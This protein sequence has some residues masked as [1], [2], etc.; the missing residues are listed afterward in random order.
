MVEPLQSS[1]PHGVAR[2]KRG[3]EL[4]VKGGKRGM[5]GGRR[6]GRSEVGVAF[7]TNAHTSLCHVKQR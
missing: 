7:A 2:R 4:L 1:D 5:E 6:E 3:C